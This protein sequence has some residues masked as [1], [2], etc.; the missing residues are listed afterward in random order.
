MRRRR[1]RRSPNRLG[2][3]EDD[4]L[5]HVRD[6]DALVDAA[7]HVVVDVL[8]LDDLDRGEVCSRKSD[9]T[10]SWYATSPSFS[11]CLIRMQCAMT[12]FCLRRRGDGLDELAVV[13]DDELARARRER[14]SARRSVK[15][16][17]RRTVPSIRSMTSSSRTAS[18]WMSSRSIGVMNVRSMPAQ[19]LVGDLVAL[20]LEAL[21]LVGDRGRPAPRR[22]RSARGSARA[23]WMRT[24]QV[25]EAVEVLLVARKEVQHAAARKRRHAI[26]DFTPPLHAGF[27]RVLTP[28]PRGKLHAERAA[29]ADL[30]LDVD[31]R[32]VQLREV[33]DDREAEARCPAASSTATGRPGRSAGRSCPAP[34][35]G[36][37][38]PRSATEKPAR[39]RPGR[40]TRTMTGA[41]SGENLIALSRRLRASW[42]SRRRSPT[43]ETPASPVTRTSTPSSRAPPASRSSATSRS[44]SLQRQI[45]S[46]SSS[47]GA[48]LDLREVHQ[49]V[50]QLAHPVGLA[51]D[52]AEQLRGLRLVG[53]A[54]GE[55]LGGRGDRGD[56]RPQ[57]VRDV[58]D[59]RAPHRLRALEARDVA[60]HADGGGAVSPPAARPRVTCQTQ[61]VR[62][63][64]GL[65]GRP[66]RSARVASKSS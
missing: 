47:H 36:I 1:A 17:T 58:A 9:A 62:E 28:R 29:L 66:R 6:A 20:V 64:H 15:S 18:W 21:D 10:A 53:P 4:A 56:R 33:L 27:A 24:R 22:R 8:P 60:Q 52:E 32:S 63:A 23:S 2:V 26:A 50:D 34:P 11:S 3:L 25:G 35:C 19:D 43:V 49:V 55:R 12:P 54:L 61:V 7:L 39:R 13:V 30:A 46:R 45:S 14:A 41:P 42:P 65:L 40:Q 44:R 38:G 16:E 51:P 37:P 59:E 5:E 48:A 57:L 31:G